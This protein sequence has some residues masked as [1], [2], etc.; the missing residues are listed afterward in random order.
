MGEYTRVMLTAGSVGAG[1]MGG[2]LF[3]FS[4]FV[5]RGLR[6]LPPG[7][8]V[9]AMQAINRAAPTPAFMLPLFGTGVLGLA[10]A[11]GASDTLGSR[12]GRLAV[13]GSVLYL[14]GLAITVA[15][16]VPMNDR[17]GRLDPGDA[18]TAAS[19][20]RYLTAWTT[21][22]HVRSAAMIGASACWLIAVS[23]ART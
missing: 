4:A 14:T 9:A 2:A 3:A 21:G 16:H 13:A 23:P 11:A 15:Y 22:N 8:G 1:A 10:I 20:S 18:R 6:Q 7:E 12:S 17:L 19:W 5:M